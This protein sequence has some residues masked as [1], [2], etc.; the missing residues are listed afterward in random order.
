MKVDV[1]RLLEA[2]GISSEESNT[3]AEEMWACCPFPEH[4]EATPSWSIRNDPSLEKHGSHYCFGCGRGGSPADL[5]IEKIGLSGYGAAVGWL[6]ERNLEIDGVAPM[7]IKVVLKRPGVYKQLE[8]P[9]GI[10]PQFKKW[11]T[12]ARRYAASRGITEAQVHRWSIGCVP[13]GPLAGRLYVP[14]Y[15]RAGM[16]LSYTARDYTGD[17]KSRYK[18]PTGKGME[19][20]HPGAIFGEEHWPMEILRKELILCEGA[21][22]ALACER[23]GARHVGALYGSD[24]SKEQ[25]LKLRSWKSIVIASDLDTAGDKM[26]RKLLA[27]LARWGNTRRVNFP[28][29]RDPNDLEQTEPKLLKELLWPK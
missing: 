27:S 19:G 25:L 15:D 24:L 9:F 21:F 22:N 1:P 16:L 10:R 20:A 4:D 29:R 12:N 6:K 5:V 23:V 3:G 2:L 14:V 11:T 26:A 8:M 7:G 18:E 13:M 17:A 28:D